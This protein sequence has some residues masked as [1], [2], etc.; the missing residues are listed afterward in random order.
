MLS[1]Y[2]FLDPPSELPGDF[3]TKIRHTFFVFAILATRPANHCLLYFT[4]LITLGDIHEFDR[5]VLP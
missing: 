1:S 2:R 4:I 5:Y 3:P